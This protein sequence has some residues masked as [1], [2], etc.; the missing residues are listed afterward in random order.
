MH[1]NDM[2]IMRPW[3]CFISAQLKILYATTHLYVIRYSKLCIIR[4]E[5]FLVSI[6]ISI[7]VIVLSTGQNYGVIGVRHQ[8]VVGMR[9]KRE[10]IPALGASAYLLVCRR[11]ATLLALCNTHSGWGGAG[12][13]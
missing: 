13:V 11:H 1:C 5:Y 4:S 10:E 9:R 8:R 6:Q 3:F 12:G 7:F 2:K